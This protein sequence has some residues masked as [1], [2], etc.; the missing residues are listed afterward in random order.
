[1]AIY[2]QNSSASPGLK[3]MS[4]GP[5]LFRNTMLSCADLAS[6]LCLLSVSAAEPGMSAHSIMPGSGR[7]R[8]EVSLDR[9]EPLSQTQITQIKFKIELIS[10]YEDI[11]CS[12]CQ[13]FSSDY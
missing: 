5:F 12:K 7:L 10:R 13:N 3:Q 1:M 6:L 11:F 4:C 8:Q 9:K 2:L